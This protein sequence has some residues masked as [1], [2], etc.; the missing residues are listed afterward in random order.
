MDTPEKLILLG[1]G[2]L[3]GGL[4]GVIGFKLHLFPESK[5]K[6][7]KIVSIIAFLVGSILII[8]GIVAQ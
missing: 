8:A 4:L 1:I 6:K 7:N 5:V 2:A 3:V